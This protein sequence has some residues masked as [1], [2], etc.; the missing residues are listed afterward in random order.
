[1]P[2]GA[3]WSLFPVNRHGSCFSDSAHK[4]GSFMS[5]RRL[6]LWMRRRL[7]YLKLSTD[8]LSAYKTCLR[9]CFAFV[10]AT[11]VIVFIVGVELLFTEKKKHKF[12]QTKRPEE[13]EWTGI[14][15]GLRRFCEF[16]S[17]FSHCFLLFIEMA[18]KLSKGK[19]KGMKIHLNTLVYLC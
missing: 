19:T 1:M 18:L 7:K 3:P 13:G 14:G 10:V 11:V 8:L 12:L 17:H 2:S 4:K 9:L 16:S 5:D 15:D 6:L